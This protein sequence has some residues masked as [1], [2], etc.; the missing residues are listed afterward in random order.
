MNVGADAEELALAIYEQVF[1]SVA[2]AR[3]RATELLTRPGLSSRAQA[4]SLRTLGFAARESNQLSAAED[5]LRRAENVA[6]DAGL[7]DVLA[8]VRLTLAL[9]RGYLGDWADALFLSEQSLDDLA[10]FEKGRGLGQH[11]LILQRLGRNSEALAVY[12]HAIEVLRANDDELGLTSFLINAGLAMAESGDVKAGQQWLEEAR[13]SAALTGRTRLEALAA[14]NAGYVAGRGGDLVT[15]MAA[16]AN[17]EALAREAVPSFLP[18]IWLDRATTLAQAGLLQEAAAL[19]QQ[20]AQARKDSSNNAEAVEFLLRAAGVLRVCGQHD[21]VAEYAQLALQRLRNENRPGWRAQA[22]YLAVVSGGGL[23]DAAYVRQLSARLRE[24]GWPVEAGEVL[25]LG[26]EAATDAGD[27]SQA[28]GLLDQL[29]DRD[30]QSDDVPAVRQIQFHLAWASLAALRQ[31]SATVEREARAGIATLTT[32]RRTLGSLELRATSGTHLRRLADLWLH[33]AMRQDDPWEVLEVLEATTAVTSM[34]AD[35]LPLSN[36]QLQAALIRLRRLDQRQREAQEDAAASMRLARQR[37]EL[38]RHIRRLDRTTSAQEEASDPTFSRATIAA[39]SADLD[40]AHLFTYEGQVWTVKVSDG[41]AT[42]HRLSTPQEVQSLAA[43]VQA[44][45]LRHLR[46]RGMT[47]HGAETTEVWQRLAEEVDVLTAPLQFADDRQAVIVAGSDAA[48]FPWALGS[49]LCRGGWV[50]TDSLRS[51]LAR[52]PQRVSRHAAE[53]VV[54]VSGPDLPFSAQ[55]IESLQHLYPAAT[56][57]AGRS[58]TGAQVQ[59]ALMDADIAHICAHG[60]VQLQNPLLSS[61][62]LVDGPLWAYELAVLPALPALLVLA[63]CG[64]GSQRRYAGGEL[65]GLGAALLRGG[66]GSVVAPTLPIVDEVAATVSLEFHRARKAG[67]PNP[68]ALC[69]A[70]ASDD[71]TPGDRFAAR[72]AMSIVQ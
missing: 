8:G 45:T 2:E 49:R 23:T 28:A 4:I 53:Q 17:A 39:A 25:L 52:A 58:S 22:D 69:R 3:K 43:R 5:F 67:M 26:A 47:A 40:L 64:V 19:A 16:L 13:A 59:R 11:A 27:A 35:L 60:D 33:E 42:L 56:V 12:Q 36:E 54:L 1:V 38:E 44:T 15:A 46:R 34:P 21:L 14:C 37:A 29:S 51:W 6:S 72:V 71:V 70:L 32:H 9:V 20:A 61:V 10:S 65:L 57:L 68:A 50:L 63:S 62:R 41:L 24:L 7:S 66:A 48:A 31:D 55:E 18:T 30:G